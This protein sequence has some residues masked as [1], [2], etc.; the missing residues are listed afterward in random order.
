MRRAAQNARLS[1]RKVPVSPRRSRTL[2]VSSRKVPP[3]GGVGLV[4]I[5]AEMVGF[6]GD[7]HTGAQAPLLEPS[8]QRIN[9][10][11]STLIGH[12]EAIGSTALVRRAGPFLQPQ[13]KARRSFIPLIQDRGSVA[14][15]HEMAQPP[16]IAHRSEPQQGPGFFRSWTGK[17]QEVAAAALKLVGVATAGSVVVATALGWSR[18]WTGPVS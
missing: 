5:N 3:G 15:D 14:E 18:G 6:I 4:G 16:L 7:R 13:A 8:P 9:L 2:L 17:H 12:Q 1:A 11:S 10:S